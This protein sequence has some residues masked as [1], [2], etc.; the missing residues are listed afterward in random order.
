MLVTDLLLLQNII[1][2]PLNADIEIL[3]RQA[4]RG[5]MRET[6]KEIDKKDF[7]NIVVHLG[8]DETFYLLK[9]VSV[10][11]AFLVVDSVLA[12]AGIDIL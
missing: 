4:S 9:A 2:T 1:R 5:S 6:L 8:T 11:I 3:V 12:A 10:T 7:T